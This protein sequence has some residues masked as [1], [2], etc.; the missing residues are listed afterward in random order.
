MCQA[1]PPFMWV[2]GVR[3]RPNAWALGTS[4]S[5]AVSRAHLAHLDDWLDLI[6]IPRKKRKIGVF[7]AVVCFI[8]LFSLALW[9]LNVMSICLEVS[10]GK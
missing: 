7:L 9:G 5:H 10:W 8:L 2:L 3:T 6:R 4:P 1:V